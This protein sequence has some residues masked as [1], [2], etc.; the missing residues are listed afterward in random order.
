M[1]LLDKVYFKECKKLSLS[2][3]DELETD[4][5]NKVYVREI[6]KKYGITKLNYYRY[7]KLWFFI[8]VSFINL[9]FYKY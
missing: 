1:N 4:I 7:K 8:A 5:A 2:Q 6:L 9:I 3:M